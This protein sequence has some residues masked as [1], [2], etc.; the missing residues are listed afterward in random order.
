MFGGPVFYAQSSENSGE[1][2]SRPRS[3]GQPPSLR[4]EPVCPW[5]PGAGQ[6]ESWGGSRSKVGK[7]NRGS[8]PETREGSL[9]R[10]S[11]GFLAPSSE[12]NSTVSHEVLTHLGRPWYLALRSWFFLEPPGKEGKKGPLRRVLRYNPNSI[13]G[14]LSPQKQKQQ[15]R[16]PV[17]AFSIFSEQRKPL[18]KLALPAERTPRQG[19]RLQPSSTLPF[20]GS[21]GCKARAEAEFRTRKE[22][23]KSWDGPRNRANGRTPRAIYLLES[24]VCPPPTPILKSTLIPKAPRGQGPNPSSKLVP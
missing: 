12:P 4:S 2:Q 7:L 13:F 5:R 20:L 11:L 18:I 6:G 23:A 1:A 21:P 22:T 24:L 17:F 14:A 16:K 8:T 10:V 19:T 15:S 9:G 3:T